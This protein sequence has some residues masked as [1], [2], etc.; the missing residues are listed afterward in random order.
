M[1]KE[2]V[3]LFRKIPVICPQKLLTADCERKKSC[4][5]HYLDN[6]AKPGTG[7]QIEVSSC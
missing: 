1:E 6:R 2:G 4:F 5:Q 3:K 7:N